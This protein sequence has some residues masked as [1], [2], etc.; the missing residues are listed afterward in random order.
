MVLAPI[1]VLEHVYATR[2]SAKYPKIVKDF[3]LPCQLGIKSLTED[4]TRSQVYKAP[5][6]KSNKAILRKTHFQN[7]Q[8]LVVCYLS[9]RFVL[10]AFCR[11][12]G[13]SKFKKFFLEK[14]LKIENILFIIF[15]L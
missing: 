4:M 7:V 5:Y 13:I 1:Q 2:I 12:N 9:F 15:S 8:L 3:I 11:K 6:L 14:N 10:L